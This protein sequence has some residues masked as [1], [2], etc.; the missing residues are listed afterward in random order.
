[1]KIYMDQD[2]VAADFE[3]FATLVLGEDFSK[4]LSHHEGT[5]CK[6]WTL[7]TEMNVFAQLKPMPDFHV[8]YD[9]VIGL[10]S[11]EGVEWCTK[12]PRNFS[13]EKNAADKK[14]WTLDYPGI[15]VFNYVTRMRDKAYKFAIG[16]DGEPNILIDDYAKNCVKFREEGGIAIQHTSAESTIKQLKEILRN[17]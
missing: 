12:V 17:R 4:Q 13:P 9:Y 16:P 6:A 15:P 7:L 1:M 8:L 2:G 3:G 10:P 5:A 11:I 14:S